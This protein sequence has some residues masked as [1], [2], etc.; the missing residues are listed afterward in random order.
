VQSKNQHDSE[1]I[2]RLKKQG[3]FLLMVYE[4][5]SAKDPTSSGT[6]SSPSNMIALRHTINQM[7]GEAADLDRGEPLC[8]MKL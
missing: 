6:E 8:C 7:Y 1:T 2:A 4:A 5:E 3:A